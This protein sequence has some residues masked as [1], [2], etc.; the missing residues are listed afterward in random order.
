M[1]THTNDILWQTPDHA[2]LISPTRGGRVLSWRHNRSS[3]LVKQQ[4]DVLDGG[5]M[6]ILLGEE[7]YP[8]ASY[9][10]PHLVISRQ[11]GPRDFHVHLRYLWNTPNALASF[12][13]W[14]D[15]TNP[16][17]TD[18][19]LLDKTIRFLP[20]QNALVLELS[21]TNLTS[22]TRYITPWVQSH[23]QGWAHDTTT[24]QDG[25]E[26][27]FL[28]HEVY[29]TGHR[30]GNAKSMRLLAHNADRTFFATLGAPVDHLDG[31]AAYGKTTYGP[32]STDACI[33]LRGKTLTLP[34]GHRFAGS[35]FLAL[36]D[37]PTQWA[38]ASPCP[39]YWRVEPAPQI[40]FTGSE[41]LPLLAHWALPDEHQSGLMIL[42]H[43]DK[44]PFSTDQR[45]QAANAFAGFRKHGKNARASI[46][47]YAL[48]NLTN[49]RAALT[50]PAGWSLGALPDSLPK[51]QLATLTLTGPATLKNKEKVQVGLSSGTERFSTL[52]I[53]QD[54]QV[55]PAYTFQIKQ[56]STYMDDRFAAERSGFPGWLAGKNLP[57]SA[58]SFHAW[59]KQAHRRACK[60]VT[61]NI[62]G[63]A[64]LKPRLLERQTGP[65]CVRDK[66]LLQTEPGVWL[67]L[68][69]IYPKGMQPGANAPGILFA[70]GSGPGKLSFAPDETADM[71]DPKIIG[72]WPSPYQFAHQLG[73]VVAIPDRRGWGEWAEGNHS[74]R[75]QRAAA[76][77]FNIT[78]LEVWDHLKTI[79]YL[80]SRP[81]VDP[82][83]VVSMGSSGGGWMT[84][85]MAGLHPHCAGGIVSSC[86]PQSASLPDQYF[87]R[88][89]GMESVT[90]HPPAV[91]PMP[92]ASICS[93]AAPKPLWV[94]DG[95]WDTGIVPVLP[96][97]PQEAQDA[98]AAW[99]KRANRGRDEIAHAYS[100]LNAQSNYQSS[101]FQGGHLA[102]F[103]LPNI[104]QWL[105]QHFPAQ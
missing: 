82:S 100:L 14:P 55:E 30:V 7:R 24:I 65:F 70:H 73:C 61:D 25:V 5:L 66:I 2:I 62:S 18:G 39:L 43:L 72:E 94:M 33:E 37:N 21:I 17:C 16:S 64:P 71:Q 68:Y 58:K 85:F 42:S 51:G 98:W 19:I 3:E 27:P 35:S 32:D 92:T 96:H 28:W 83:R 13:G 31:M 29:W 9:I 102:G 84:I 41:L 75:P 95:L 77:G 89:F 87:S 88:T 48:K 105:S 74:Q 22:A 99:H 50:A 10:T 47:L 67:P 15:K 38:T 1:T 97:T 79:D 52:K 36:S 76:A 11:N 90:L 63:P 8:G 45:Y 57:P 26:G 49:L 104:A 23:F 53:P 12:L 6:R 34:P 44:V 69:L 46:G 59:Q 40:T 103:T 91:L 20:A 86:D 101:W 56:T 80:R 93:L 78:A 81:E 54:A 60:W 4:A